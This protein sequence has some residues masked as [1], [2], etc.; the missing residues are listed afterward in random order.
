[1]PDYSFAGLSTRSFEQ[2]IQAIATKVLGPN[3]IIFGD[4]PDGGREATYE[5]PTSYRVGDK[6]WNGYVVVQAKFRQRAESMAKDAAWAL[7][8]LS[9]E[10]KKF[11]SR[12]R[13][14]RCP[15]YYIFATNV[16]LSP[17]Y[18]T[19]SKDKAYAQI[20]KAKEKLGI[21][22]FDVWDYDKLRTFLDDAE[23]I[24]NGYGA[25]IT[26]GDV[27]AKVVST[28]QLKTANFDEIL[29]NFLQ[30][31]LLNDR[32]ANLEQA[33][34][35]VE[36]R[37]P[38]ATVF[39]DL[40]V[41]NESHAEPPAE[42]HV[43]YG[44]V[45][46]VLDA[47][48]ERFNDETR[49]GPPII[50][51]QD[52]LGARVGRY[53]LVGG[54]GQGKTTI[55]QFICQL[56]RVAVLARKPRKGLSDD[57]REAMTEIQDQ[58][59]AEGI[60]IPIVRRFPIRVVLSEFATV[61]NSETTNL[62]SYIV[63]RIKKKTQKTFSIDDFR[64][65]LSA[66]PWILVLDGLDE[67]PAS[68]NRE[69]LLNAIRDFWIDATECNADI[70]VIATTR[71]QGYD[72]DFSPKA[73]GHKWLAPLSS[74]RALHYAKRLVD[75][76]YEGEEDRKDKILSRLR[77]ACS[78]DSTSR[79]MRSPLQ[80][81]IMAT[82]VD[83]VG[84]PPQERWNLFKDYYTVIYEREME[85]DTAAAEI[86]RNYRVDVNAIHARVGLLLQVESEKT[87]RTNARLP[88]ER[89]KTI[90]GLHLA[91]EGHVGK[92]LQ[93]LQD[94]IIKA[95]M[96][97]LVF[98]VGL[99][100]KQ[101]GF[102]VRSLQEF[103]AAEGLMQGSEEDVRPRLHKLSSISHWRNVFLFAAGKCF[104]ERLHLRD[105]IH[106]ICSQ[107][108]EDENNAV[109]K[110]LTGSQ[111]AIDLLEDGPAKKQPK[112]ASIL[113]RIALRILESPPTDYQI[114]LASLFT[115]EFEELFTQELTKRLSVKTHPE[116]LGAWNMLGQLSRKNAFA[117]KLRD[118]YWPTERNEYLATIP[119]A[120][121]LF[122]LYRRLLPV[123]VEAGPGCL[124]LEM[125]N[126]TF[127]MRFEARLPKSPPWFETLVLANYRSLAVHKPEIVF[128]F[129]E[130][131]A[132]Q[133]LRFVTTPFGKGQSDWLIPL[134]DMPDTNPQWL[135]SIAS[136]RFLHRPSKDGLA[137]QLR[138][139]A[140]RGT[141]DLSENQPWYVP[142]P[143]SVCIGRR[144]GRKEL[145]QLAKL[146]EQGELGDTADWVAAEQRWISR[147]VTLEDVEYSSTLPCRLSPDLKDRGFPASALRQMLLSNWAALSVDS[148]LS[149]RNRLA[150]TPLREQFAYRLLW[151]I[152]SESEYSNLKDVTDYKPLRA[153]LLDIPAN[154]YFHVS[155]LNH[156]FPDKIEDQWI[157]V[158]DDIGIKT[159]LHGPRRANDTVCRELWRLFISKPSRHGILRLL[160]QMSMTT[161][162]PEIPFEHLDPSQSDDF[163]FRAAAIIVLLSQK[164]SRPPA[165][166]LGQLASTVTT[167]R[168]RFLHQALEAIRNKR[169]DIEFANEFLLSLMSHLP[170]TDTQA[171]EL[172]MD[173][174]NSSVRSRISQLD[175]PAVWES[176]KLPSLGN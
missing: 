163:K 158:L 30:K 148:M 10:L 28:L 9:A 157:E 106:T 99:E 19:G 89:F 91:E 120:G 63:N 36:D 121:D 61:L 86:L 87:G 33:G 49:Q 5:G 93:K 154:I 66:Y 162:V 57:V 115:P 73:Y 59:D 127:P 71:P 42:E 51:L 118:L 94:E 176:L 6:S 40:P 24:R 159:W 12:Q 7:A 175:D 117:R 95:A 138:T 55:G 92:G 82:L 56:F 114:K 72:D 113:F 90:V 100:Q 64:R 85:R 26:A 174:L 23:D 116:Q 125:Y 62:L 1:M 147:G 60:S 67:V 84:T 123:V 68:S 134:K 11:L 132:Q 77:R 54:P 102:E 78:Q 161:Q 131:R 144:E 101:I 108:N 18:K 22:G 167:A 135:L 25:W 83:K 111:L 52:D 129:P 20:S 44:F 79:L 110:V 58:C 169:V 112:Y 170:T 137:E 142:W 165:S 16:V 4:G 150:T 122:D 172:V 53:V 173:G 39:V 104:S 124:G 27:L 105:T 17:V 81:T 160:A 140:E 166:G 109:R 37:I 74:V 136:A 164:T 151:Y 75:I 130:S 143:L 2:L 43:R 3:T 155:A 88:I 119:Y 47:A 152:S 141:D 48:R 65:W 29:A 80:V 171:L 139:L 107:L 76:R 156:L 21:K 146:A 50:G 41:L 133:V 97:R 126:Y 31:E 149:I 128:R 15:E 168:Y 14:L 35:T 8:Q 13:N 34:H 45:S 98:L 145:E 103:M 153:L 32:Y 96:H 70:L 38:L 69:D 46:Q